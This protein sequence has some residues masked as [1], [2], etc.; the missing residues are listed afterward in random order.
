MVSPL[1]EPAN[2]G[3]LQLRNRFVR[4]AT[5]EAMAT[6]DGRPTRQLQDL[7]RALAGGQVGL[8]ITSGA[9][10]EPWPNAP[11]SIGVRS[12]LS[13]Y[14]DSFID[15]WTQ[16][17]DAVHGA[18]AKIAMQFGHLGRQDIPLL[19]GSDPLA[20]SPVPIKSTGII[21]Q[22]ISV[23]QIADVVEKFALACR[24]IQVAGFDAAQFHGAHGNIMTNFMS[25]FTN[26]RNDS[27]GGC[28]ENRARLLL[29]VVLRSRELVG[30]DYPIIIKLSFS[31][32]VDGGLTPEDAVTI[33]AMLAEAG[34]SAIEVSGGT[35]SET[36]ERIS[37]KNIKSEDQEAY[38]LPFAKALKSRVNIPIIL[39]GGL[40]SPGLMEKILKEG[41]ADFFALSRPLIREADLIKRW[42]GGDRRKAKCV[43]CNQCFANWVFHPIRC[44]IDHPLDHDPVSKQ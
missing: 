36:P 34:V 26:R 30:P 27:Y 11:A 4:S 44:F 31:D 37:E 39:V 14:D 38:F 12:P 3:N 18:G 8:I 19:R 9:M 13:I 29:E 24:R 17:I 40:R 7:Y 25:P 43:S 32:F 33:A 21:P 5:A 10:I 6:E 22:E 42:S 23:A 15:D 1:F 28:P 41:S 35:L 16:V 20:P 2:I